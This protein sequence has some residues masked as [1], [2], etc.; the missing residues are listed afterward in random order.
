MTKDDLMARM[1]E[2]TTESPIDAT[3]FMTNGKVRRNWPKSID[4]TELSDNGSFNANAK[5]LYAGGCTS[6]GQYHKTFDNYQ[7]LTGVPNGI[8]TVSVKGPIAL[9]LTLLFPISMPT[10][11]K[12][13]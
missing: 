6:Y 5:G 12:L 11:R 13:T 10:I 9:I 7:S 4:E 1:G 2:A 3:F 8:Y